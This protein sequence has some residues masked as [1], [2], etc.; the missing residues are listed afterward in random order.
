MRT[1]TAGSLVDQAD[2]PAIVPPPLLSS[3][4][5]A[6]VSGHRER[7][8]LLKQPGALNSGRSSI[9]AGSAPPRSQQP[10]VASSS[11]ADPVLHAASIRSVALLFSLVLEPHSPPPPPR[12]RDDERL[13]L[14]LHLARSGPRQS[15]PR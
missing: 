6:S 12:S 14:P 1:N 10:T 9:D 8:E 3:L 7:V 11:R 13:T 2:A 4:S 5:A 15:S